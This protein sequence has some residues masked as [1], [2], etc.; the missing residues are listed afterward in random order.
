M[1]YICCSKARVNLSHS[2][3]VCL[4]Y[5]EAR[6]SILGLI[7][8]EVLVSSRSET[9]YQ[10]WVCFPGARPDQIQT[11]QNTEL[12]SDLNCHGT[13]FNNLGQS[14]D[15]KNG[16]SMASHFHRVGRSGNEKKKKKN[17][18]PKFFPYF[19]ISE[20]VGRAKKKKNCRLLY[21]L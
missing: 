9:A 6:Y 19:R 15:L 7:I 13:S 8:F 12:D 17:G 14:V 4:A 10:Y 2:F 1:E 16:G 11:F 18:W 21:E 3:Q 5:F 20:S